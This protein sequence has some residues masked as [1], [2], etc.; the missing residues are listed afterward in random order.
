MTTKRGLTLRL[1]LGLWDRV[2]DGQGG[3]NDRRER[4]GG[5][6]DRHGWSRSH[7]G[8]LGENLRDA[9]GG[10]HKLRAWG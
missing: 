8:H 7:L 1:R 10:L 9:D 5:R 4:V 6:S 3:R 2:P